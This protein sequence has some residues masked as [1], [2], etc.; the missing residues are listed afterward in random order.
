VQ[1]PLGRTPPLN[2]PVKVTVTI[3]PVAGEQKTDNNTST[4]TV[5]FSS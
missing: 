2:S 1:V 3:L 5:I 4:Y